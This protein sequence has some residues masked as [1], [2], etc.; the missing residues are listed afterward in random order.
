MKNLFLILSITMLLWS[1]SKDEHEGIIV[2]TSVSIS[3]KDTNG[4]D[5]LDANNSNSLNLDLVKII[6]EANGEKTVFLKKHLD[7]PKGFSV[8]KHEKEYRMQVLLNSDKQTARPITYIQWNDTDT[9]TLK[10]EISRKSGNEICNKLWL[11]NKL[12]WKA[13]ANERH[14]EL[15]K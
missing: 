1:C 6:Y 2:D 12:V 5:L 13:Y 8:I 11:N 14:L 10:C 4:N 9:D 15:I 7:A 3:V